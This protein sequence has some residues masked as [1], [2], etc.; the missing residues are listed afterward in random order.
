M[1]GGALTFRHGLFLY[2]IYGVY[3]CDRL[4]TRYLHSYYTPSEAR[5]RRLECIV[6]YVYHKALKL[7]ERAVIG[8]NNG[9]PF[10]LSKCIVSYFKASRIR[11]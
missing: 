10:L 8:C 7:L 3:P 2:L 9:L 4:E 6:V 1:T 11:G 5:E